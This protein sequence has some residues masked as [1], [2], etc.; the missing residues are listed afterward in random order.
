MQECHTS[1]V[2][3]STLSVGSAGDASSRAHSSREEGRS[4]LPR[5]VSGHISVPGSLRSCRQLQHTLCPLK[6]PTFLL[7][8]ISKYHSNYF[9]SSYKPC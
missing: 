7:L 2:S 4:A 9:A 1:L 6:L 5:M 3:R 8:K